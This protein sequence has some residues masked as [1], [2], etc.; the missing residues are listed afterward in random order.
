MYVLQTGDIDEVAAT[1]QRMSPA[2]GS[3]ILPGAL[4]LRNPCWLAAFV[5]DTMVGL[6]GVETAVDA[7]VISRLAVPQSERGVGAALVSAARKAAHT[8]GAR[9]LY[10]LG[11]EDAKRLESIGFERVEAAE[12]LDDLAGTA[13]AD[14]LLALPGRAVQL[15]ALRLDISRDG[16]IER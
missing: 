12:M 11:G 10:T 4:E 16:I 8:R 5:G 6:A 3:T 7:A 1:L 15:V 9:R 13:F 2:A 14:Y